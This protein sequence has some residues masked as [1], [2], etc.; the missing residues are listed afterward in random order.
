MRI[1]FWLISPL[2]LS[3]CIEPP[4]AY[5]NESAPA[6]PEHV[7]FSIRDHRVGQWVSYET[8]RGR[9][10]WTEKKAVVGGEGD[11]LWIELTEQTGSVPHITALLVGPSG[12]VSRAC[13][14]DPGREGVPMTIVP[15]KPGKEEPPPTVEAKES[16]EEVHAAGRTFRCRK[17]VSTARHADGSVRTLTTWYSDSVPFATLH[18]GKPYGGLVKLEGSSTRKVLTGFGTDAK[19]ELRHP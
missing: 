6:A 12:R 2:L 3:G 7:G 18:E 13:Y 4:R 8:E 10:R 19:P 14:G 11:A 5:E 17:V 15:E 16:E 1:A 9:E